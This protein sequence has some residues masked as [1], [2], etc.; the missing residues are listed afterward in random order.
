MCGIAGVLCANRAGSLHRE[1]LPGILAALATALHHRG[2]DGAQTLVVEGV[3]LAHTRLSII[4]LS[5]SGTQPMESPDG[6]YAITYNGETYNFQSLRRDL[7]ATGVA[8]RGTS[9]TE[10]VLH[11][12]ARQGIDGLTRLDGMFALALL[13]KRNGEVLLARD[14]MGQKPLY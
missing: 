2:P 12:L 7:E 14:R 4:D 13:D 5:P 11:I 6:R 10:V 9:D 8:F 3:G 1:K